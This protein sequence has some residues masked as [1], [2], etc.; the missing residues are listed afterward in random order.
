MIKTILSR[1]V[2]G[3]PTLGGVKGVFRKYFVGVYI[4]GY[5]GGYDAMRKNQF[6]TLI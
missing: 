6:F 5:I 1:H 2:Q 3:I 4:G